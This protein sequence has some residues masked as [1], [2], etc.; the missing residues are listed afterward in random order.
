MIC[1]IA[2]CKKNLLFLTLCTVMTAFLNAES[3]RVSKVNTISISS[4]DFSEC[5]AKLGINES[6]AIFIPEDR[7]FI[8]G[9]EVKMSIPSELASWPD[10][11]ACTLYNKI[12]PVPSP[13]K[14]DYTGTKFY[15][16][17]LPGKLSWILQ[18]P[19][20]EPN[21]LKSNNYTTKTELL[22]D[23]SNNVIFLRFQPIMKGISSETMESKVNISV[24]PILMDKGYLD[25]DFNTPNSKIEPCTIYIDNN[26]VTEKNGKKI[27]L[28]TGVH[29]IS[30]ISE[31]YRTEVR[32]VRIEQAKTTTISIDLKSIEPTLLVIA[33]EGTTVLVDDIP[34]TKFGTEFVISEGDHKVQFNVGDY[35]IIRNITA[36][37]GRTYTANFTVDLQI[38]EE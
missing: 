11:V 6:L 10:C 35:Q 1:R 15:V 27:L 37:K 20:K 22:Q 7:T 12:S 19:L 38:T 18:I 30:L 2:D 29:N 26:L 14:I 16:S 34:C 21:S 32:T 25:I 36:I 8:E 17:T 13:S 33:P 3:F 23:L 24:K 9:L 5:S 28:D 4:D 31:F